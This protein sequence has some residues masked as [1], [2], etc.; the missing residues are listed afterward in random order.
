[1]A[2]PDKKTRDAN[3]RALSTFI[4]RRAPLS[5]VDIQKLWKG[6]FYAFWLSDKPLVQL[7]L[8]RRISCMQTS[9]T[10]Q[11]WSDWMT[12]FFITMQR[13]WNGIDRLRMDKYLSLVSLTLH[14]S[15]RY[16]A[17]T[18]RWSESA[19]Q[20]WVA[21]YGQHPL[22][23]SNEQRGLFLHL[24]D[25]FVTELTK[26]VEESG[27]PPPPFPMLSQLLMPFLAILASPPSPSMAQ[28]V[29][30]E[31]L[32]P[33]ITLAST[34]SD[35]TSRLHSVLTTCRPQL[36][37]LL[38]SLAADRSAPSLLHLTAPVRSR[39]MSALHV[40][41]RGALL[42]APAVDETRFA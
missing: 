20:R 42:R 31:L 27:G 23:A 30:T 24:A 16:V 15:L 17:V 29:E 11:R 22:Q 5:P 35:D 37:D 2:H 21:V 41:R 3:V 38:S 12:G 6:L 28:R 40:S 39:V 33:L 32:T 4:Q 18:H 36:I 1:M 8:A 19:V 26:V 9:L 14:H 10:P 7:D 13:E 25:I 34:T